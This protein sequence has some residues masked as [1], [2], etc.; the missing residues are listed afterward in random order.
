MG[1]IRVLLVEDEELFSDLLSRAFATL[2]RVKL[3]GTARN[4]SEALRLAE[5]LRPDVV[6]LDIDLG[7]GPNGI[8]VAI[9]VRANRPETGIVILTSHMDRQYVASLLEDQAAGWSYL[10][11]QSVTDVS[12]LSR[13][14][15]G[16]AAGMVY[17]DH[18]VLASLHPRADTRVG[19][20]S[21]QQ[22]KI[23]ML[24]AE[25]YTDDGIAETM[26]MEE[27]LVTDEIGRI[28]RRLEVDD[29]G[30]VHPRVKAVLIL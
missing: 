12:S 26:G 28:F 29:D 13:A 8:E 10:L 24:M 5:V 15:E 27:Q 6:I 1:P 30:P 23:L 19:R 7:G 16:A 22:R 2:D 3:V 18:T 14:I 17:I 9:R 20:L 11:K 4:G 21:D 25:G